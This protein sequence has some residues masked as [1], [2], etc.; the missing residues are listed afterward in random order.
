V[1]FHGQ[2]GSPDAVF[3]QAELVAWESEAPGAE[4][5]VH[6]IKP[7]GKVA[8]NNFGEVAF[9]GKVEAGV[10]FIDIIEEL[11]AVFI[12]AGEVVKVGD[13]LSDDAFVRYIDENGG[14]AINDFGDVAVHGQVVLPDGGDPVPAVF[15][16]DEVVV[17]KGDTL[18]DN[19]IVAAIDVTGGV[20]INLFGLVAVHGQVVLPD[21]GDPVPAVFTQEGVVVKVGDTLSDGTFVAEIDR[22]GGVAINFFGDVAFHGR[23]GNLYKSVFTQ[24]GLVA[25][26]NGILPDDTIMK[27]ITQ[28]AGVAINPYGSQV[29]FIGQIDTASNTD[30]VF[31]GEA[32]IAVVPAE[33]D[34]MSSE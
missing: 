5:A 8:I 12:Q 26:V 1:A 20:A 23:N 28:N 15:T 33:S 32:P 9:H 25:A 7:A 19:T 18:T 3:T 27:R 6:N 24:G 14:V 21:G 11:R 13:T 2:A 4:K 29:A 30:L 17:K 10:D 22:I 16:Q 31:V 34:E